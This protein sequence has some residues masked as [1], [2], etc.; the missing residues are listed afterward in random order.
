MKTD[1]FFKF[2]NKV[3]FAGVDVVCHNC[4][5]FIH[6]NEIAHMFFENTF[7]SYIFQCQKCFDETRKEFDEFVNIF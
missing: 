5:K 4:K 1:G 7:A 2:I 3:S 6:S